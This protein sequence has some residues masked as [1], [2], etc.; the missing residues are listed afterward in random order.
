MSS[1]LV[2]IATIVI[3]FVIGGYG[4]YAN[5]E[6][7]RRTQTAMTIGHG[8]DRMVLHAQELR[9]ETGHAPG[10]ASAEASTG[11]GSYDAGYDRAAVEARPALGLTY[12]YVAN[13]SGYWTCAETIRV[14]DRTR[15]ALT[16]VSRDRPG[17]F[18]SGRC[19]DP[20]AAIGSAA[21]VSM[22]TL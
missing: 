3:V 8:L 20:S 19:G 11:Y 6:A 22:R 14:D 1:V 2:G 17:S 16:M 4:V 21:V 10:S 9:D 18:V 7:S 15:E 5:V 13:G 12:R